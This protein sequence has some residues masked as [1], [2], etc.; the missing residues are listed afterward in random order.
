[1]KFNA[2]TCASLFLVSLSTQGLAQDNIAPDA[3]PVFDDTLQATGFGWTAGIAATTRLSTSDD[4]DHAENELEGFVELTYGGFHTAL[5]ATSLYQDPDDDV[6]FEIN[7]GYGS[8]FANGMSWDLT[9]GYL[10]LDDTDGHAEEVTASLGFPVSQ[11]TETAFAVI[12]DPDTGK[13]DQ[14]IEFETALNDSWALVGLVG[15]SDRDDNVYGEIG[16]VYALDDQTSFQVLYEDTN[17]D[18][19]LLGFSVA[20]EFGG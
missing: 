13:S 1:M 3:N 2:L 7:L 4:F 10:F 16:V 5:V 18:G 20:Y 12:Y 11:T 17:D 8:E 19:G 6:E 14:E 9:Y 15:N